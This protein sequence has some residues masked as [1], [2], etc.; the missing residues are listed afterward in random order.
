MCKTVRAVHVSKSASHDWLYLDPPEI[1][2]QFDQDR[3]PA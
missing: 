3:V 1:S 2:I